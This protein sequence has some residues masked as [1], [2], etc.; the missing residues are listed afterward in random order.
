MGDIQM[1]SYEL[2]SQDN[3]RVAYT[4]TLPDISI[5]KLLDEVQKEA[6]R[7]HMPVEIS[8]VNVITPESSTPEQRLLIKHKSLPYSL[9]HILFSLKNFGT[10]VFA[11]RWNCLVKE[12]SEP[13]GEPKSVVSPTRLIVY[14]A[15]GAC[16]LLI[17]AF[18]SVASLSSLALSKDNS[19]LMS[20]VCCGAPFLLTGLGFGGYGAFSWK[21]NQ[22]A[23]KWNKE[24]ERQRTQYFHELVEYWSNLDKAFLSQF[25]PT[26]YHL[27]DAAGEVIDIVLK[28]LYPQAQ[29]GAPQ[30]ID[31]S[32]ETL[33][34]MKKLRESHVSEG[35]LKKT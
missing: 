35:K 1:T 30:Q 15:G 29:I 17:G 7:F 2:L 23:I 6:P 32:K 4:E 18:F 16:A 13:S 10:F 22:E 9:F 26:L 20:L 31:N 14:M 24:L 12:P 34:R 8:V 25:D 3:W 27:R 28:R 19:S 5:D 21:S 11:N 33:E